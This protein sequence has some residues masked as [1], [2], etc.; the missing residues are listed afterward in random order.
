VLRYVLRVGLFRVYGFDGARGKVYSYIGV[1]STNSFS[2][3]L[4][5]LTLIL[6][7]YIERL[8]GAKMVEK[9]FPFYARYCQ[10]P[11]HLGNQIVYKPASFVQEWLR[12]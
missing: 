8:K 9:H 7:I 11:S 10:K 2:F 3:D 12:I 1:F 6:N 5:K 4:I